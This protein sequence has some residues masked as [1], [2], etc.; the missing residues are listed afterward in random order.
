MV[1]PRI[2][3]IIESIA[4]FSAGTDGSKIE[5]AFGS[6]EAGKLNGKYKV[7]VNTYMQE[8][9]VL[10]G[11]KGS[12]YLDSGGVFAPYIPLISTPLIYDPTTFKMTKMLS[13]RYAKKLTLKNFFG[14][15]FVADLDNL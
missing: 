5:Y 14:K 4:G 6:K 12:N 2:A 9:V 7:I 8:N 13:T 11:F 3:S 10:M 1:G 15:V